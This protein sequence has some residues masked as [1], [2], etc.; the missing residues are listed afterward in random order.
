[1]LVC[2]GPISIAPFWYI[3]SFTLEWRPSTRGPNMKPDPNN[4]KEMEGQVSLRPFLFTF[5]R[6]H[7]VLWR[8]Q[9]LKW[10]KELGGKEGWEVKAPKDCILLFLQSLRHL[11]TRRKRKKNTRGGLSSLAVI[12]EDQKIQLITRERR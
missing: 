11:K 7:R 10:R 8:E 5:L 9:D 3:K 2:R 1:M 4:E 6:Q 12:Q